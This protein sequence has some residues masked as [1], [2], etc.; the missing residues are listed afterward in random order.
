MFITMSNKIVQL[1]D[2]FQFEGFKCL[3]GPEEEITGEQL[4]EITFSK[5][6]D[7]E[8]DNHIAIMADTHDYDKLDDVI[9]VIKTD[10]LIHAGDFGTPES[11]MK[12][13]KKF[14]G[15]FFGVLGNHDRQYAASFL[16]Y[17]NYRFQMGYL[18]KRFTIDNTLVVHL[19]HENE[20]MENLIYDSPTQMAGLIIY[21]HSHKPVFFHKNRMTIV[22]PG[23][24]CDVGNNKPTMCLYS[25]N[26]PKESVFVV[27]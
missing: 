23:I 17:L 3:Y 16:P 25:M 24:L 15:M 12:S 21:G 6:A 4:K 26:N 7:F 19:R 10:I 9:D 22:N 18:V 20:G 13:L 14:N 8:F 27:S 11:A 2:Q 5:L 1:Y